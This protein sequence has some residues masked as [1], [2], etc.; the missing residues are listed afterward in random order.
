MNQI[1]TALLTGQRSVTIKGVEVDLK[2][3]PRDTQKQRERIAI[4][5]AK[6]ILKLI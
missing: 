2:P 4:K 5:Q 1:V 6:E 3:L